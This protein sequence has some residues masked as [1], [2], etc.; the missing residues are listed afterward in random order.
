MSS[1]PASRLRAARAPGGAPTPGRSAAWGITVLGVEAL[2]MAAVPAGVDLRRITTRCP[3]GGAT[4]CVAGDANDGSSARGKPEPSPWSGG[5]DG[6]AAADG[7]AG[8]RNPRSINAPGP[9]AVR[10]TSPPAARRLALPSAPGDCE[11][12][13][14]NAWHAAMSGPPGRRAPSAC[15]KGPPP[16]LSDSSPPPPTLLSS[17]MPVILLKLASP[18]SSLSWSQFPKSCCVLLSPPCP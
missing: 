18:F 14:C 13:A 2:C 17:C 10:N 12:S 1:M 16:L 3:A 8:A 6:G 15:G 5:N 7:A 9:S 11:S 4:T